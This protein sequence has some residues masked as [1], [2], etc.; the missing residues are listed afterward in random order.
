MD[1]GAQPL[2]VLV[3]CALLLS[4][5]PL[6]AAGQ[7]AVRRV[8]LAEAL[9]SLATNSLAL[10]IARSETA[11]ATGAA[12][13]SRAYSNPALSVG[14]DDLSHQDE[15]VW[16][17]TFLLTQQ[18]EW[19]ARTAAR[20][21]AARHTIGAGTA[22]LRADSISLAFEVREAYVQAWLAEETESLVQRAASV[23]RSVADDA[24]I[25]L[26]AGDISAYEARR[27]RLE[28]VQIELEL[29]EAGLGARDARRRLA[30]LV[31]P[32]TGAEE[33]GPSEGLTGVPPLITR[34]AAMAALPER[35]DVGSGR[36]GVGCCPCGG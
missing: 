33:V 21:R 30:V 11:E 27:L 3:A 6:A 4:L 19:P 23:I 5:S 15:K 22:R 32:G 1:S 10:K 34:E 29:Q 12:R 7:D 9:E 25:R 28:R 35:P 26:A 18:V 36:Q 17:E 14:R 24:E 31:V 8:S 2:P 20:A 13:Q 16:E